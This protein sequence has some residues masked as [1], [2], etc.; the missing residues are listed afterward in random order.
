[1]DWGTGKI[2][3]TLMTQ[4]MELTWADYIMRGTENRQTTTGTETQSRTRRGQDRRRA[5]REMKLVP[6]LEQDGVH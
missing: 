3:Y 6:F 2:I 5:G 4:N 1:M